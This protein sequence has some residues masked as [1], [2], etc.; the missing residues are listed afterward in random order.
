[1]EGQHR[2]FTVNLERF[3]CT[4]RY[5]DLSGLPCCHAI[6][7]IYRVGKELDDFIAPCYRID[8][9]DQVYNH[10]LEPV[11]GKESWPLAPNPRPFPPVGKKKPGR[12]KVERKREEQEKP[13]GDKISR[14]GGTVR[15]SACG[16]PGHNKRKCTA[17]PDIVREH[18]HNKK[19]AKRSRRK[20]D[21]APQE[22]TS[23]AQQQERHVVYVEKKKRKQA[24]A[25]PQAVAQ[26][27]A[28]AMRPQ[29]PLQP[30]GPAMR[31]FAPPKKKH[32]I[33]GDVGPGS[34]QQSQTASR[35]EQVPTRKK[36][37]QTI[38]MSQVVTE[39]VPKHGRMPWLLG[40]KRKPAGYG[41]DN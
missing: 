17:N 5:W 20:Q 6:S 33:S 41:Q 11:E 9:Y 16:R 27:H 15:C 18:A 38:P 31:P 34:S 4:C 12:P 35:Q 7:A 37:S 8:V 10:V 3:T 32:H 36:S 28:P 25:E 23:S 30:Q 22:A 40:Q 24:P 26:P 1:M 2:R 21:K 13:K 29:V 14:K 39:N 19:A